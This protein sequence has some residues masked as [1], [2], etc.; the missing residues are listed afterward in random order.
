MSSGAA[1]P[2]IKDLNMANHQQRPN[3]VDEARIVLRPSPY[4]FFT[5]KDDDCP[6]VVRFQQ[7][8]DG[9][10]IILQL[11]V[12]R[13]FQRLGDADSTFFFFF[14]NGGEKSKKTIRPR[15]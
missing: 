8:L 9:F 11:G 12:V 6:R 2:K 10:V 7:L 1:T 14:F 4:V 13:N 5:G 15:G 3:V